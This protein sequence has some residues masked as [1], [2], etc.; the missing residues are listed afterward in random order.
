VAAFIL[1]NGL[2]KLEVAAVGQD[3]AG[4]VAVRVH[5]V[6]RLVG[7]HPLL[8]WL[9]LEVRHGDGQGKLGAAMQA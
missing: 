7:G 8:E 3:L 4:A 5:G 9:D 1:R 6:G 2:I